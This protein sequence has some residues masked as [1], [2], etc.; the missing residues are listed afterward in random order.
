VNDSTSD[1]SIQKNRLFIRHARNG[2]VTS[3]LIGSREIA[4]NCRFL[5]HENN[6]LINVCSDVSD[7]DTKKR[8]VDGLRLAMRRFDL[9]CGLA[10][11]LNQSET[12]PVPEGEI[13][14]L[15]YRRWALETERWCG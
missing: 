12:M 8:E 13:E 4:G 10:V 11:T 3:Y 6:A 9:D 15:P 14:F 1:Y 5:P 2:A 7:A